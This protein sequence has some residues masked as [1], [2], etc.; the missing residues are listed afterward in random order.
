MKGTVQ[1][2]DKKIDMVANAFSPYL[3]KQIMREDFLV[4]VQEKD[5]DPDL[6]VKMG[7]VMAKQAELERSELYKLSMEEYFEWL[8]GFDPM[9][10][11]L[12]TDAIA[13]IYFDQ[14]QNSSLPKNE[15]G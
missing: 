9:D 1:I 13:K 14:E 2:G 11:M 5:P 4:K 10:P 15:A 12:A 8:E 6:F 7:F 3:Y